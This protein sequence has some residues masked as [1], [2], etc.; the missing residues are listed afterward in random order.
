MSKESG[1]NNVVSFDAFR[2]RKKAGEGARG[3]SPKHVEEMP[4]YTQEDIKTFAGL[5]TETA[6]PALSTVLKQRLAMFSGNGSPTVKREHVERMSNEEEFSNELLLELVKKACCAVDQ[7]LQMN[8][9]YYAALA[10]VCWDRGEV[11]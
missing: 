8:P 3:V 10:D 4:N 1:P 7:E 9:A 2:E 11:E 5:R 6:L